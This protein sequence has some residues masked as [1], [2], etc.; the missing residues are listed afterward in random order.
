MKT[1]GTVVAKALMDSRILDLPFN[2]AFMQL[3]LQQELP[4]N[5]ASVKVCLQTGSRTPSDAEP[6]C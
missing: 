4:L 2:R 6:C 1:L 3:V 5:L